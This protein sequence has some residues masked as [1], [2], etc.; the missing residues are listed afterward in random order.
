MGDAL[1]DFS[2]TTLVDSTTH[3]L[4]VTATNQALAS[5]VYTGTLS[6]LSI[7]APVA[8]GGI[9]TT[10]SSSSTVYGAGTTGA[11][12]SSTLLDVPGTMG[13]LR[14]ALGSAD[15]TDTVAIAGITRTSTSAA[16]SGTAALTIT[17]QFTATSGAGSTYTVAT[18]VLSGGT[19]NSI[20]LGAG[21]SM[22]VVYNDGTN[23][24]ITTTYTNTTANAISF[25]LS[26]TGD[27]VTAADT[28]ANATRSYKLATGTVST[29]GLSIPTTGSA[30]LGGNAIV[31]SQLAAANTSVTY[32][33]SGLS[34]LTTAGTTTVNGAV[35]YDVTHG[36]ISTV[37]VTDVTATKVGATSVTYA[38]T[39][40]H[41]TFSSGVNV[42]SDNKTIVT[43]D[44]LTSAQNQLSDALTSL[45]TAASGFGNNN[46]IV[47]TRQDFTTK[48]VTTLQKASDNLVLADTNEEGANLQALQASSS[49][50]IIA[51]GISGQQAQAILRLF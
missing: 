14:D 22:Q 38:A 1:A 19:A 25:N 11:T 24:I 49:L 15:G 28:Q 46:T 39:D 34:S 50:G 44:A 27:T 20:S 7:T 26:A 37:L 51:L 32:K 4:T 6:A 41:V 9:G 13:A 30:T 43:A 36:V 40:A 33:D 42:L 47:S 10:I 48:L 45:R 31:D 5:A 2:S 21:Q 3:A 8:A 17:G 16:A 35:A 18:G 29:T 23:P 12:V